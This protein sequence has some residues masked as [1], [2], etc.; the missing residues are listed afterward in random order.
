[1]GDQK[2]K[3]YNYIIIGG[4]IV[5]SGILRDLSLHDQSALLIDKK[6][7]N[8]QTSQSSSK[9][10]HGGIRYLE[11]LDFALVLEALRE[12]NHW[13]K[14]APDACYEEEFHFPI[15]KESKYPFWML[16]IGLFLYDLL[17][18]FKNTPHATITG[19]SL[20]EK[21]GFL[22]Q[23]NLKGVGVYCDAVVDDAKLGLDCIY[24]ALNNPKVDAINYKEVIEVSKTQEGYCVKVKDTLNGA[25][26]QFHCQSVLFATGP[27]TDQVMKKLNLP[28][29]PR[30]VPSKG[31]HIWLSARDLNIKKSVVLQTKDERVIFIIPQGD[32]ILVGTTENV[33]EADENYFDL[34]PSQTEI[35][36]LVE[37]I[38]EYFPGNKITESKIVASY[39]GVRPLVKKAGKN[40]S[41]LS[42]HH[43]VIQVMPNMFAIIGGKYT[44]FRVMAADIV[45]KA[46]KA[47]HTRYHSNLSLAPLKS[48]SIA[49]WLQSF[50]KEMV[51][52][53]I[54]KEKVRTFEDL[55][56]RRLSLHDLDNLPEWLTDYQERLKSRR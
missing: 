36:Y 30:I 22:K 24:D 32:Y 34:K 52:E 5:G 44:T 51:D 33:L 54:E 6:D 19:R 27:F 37:H 55:Y 3:H 56:R 20:S 18:F 47:N 29:Q 1:M 42:R 41:K 46:F 38:N 21:V 48:K 7:F 31:S 17:S 8:S 26:N 39:A 23:E 43:Q 40:S 15:Y 10:L 13:L 9:M 14:V 49:P 16:R 2:I 4:G 25:I 11:N 12:K 45:K 53:I 28:W 50:N 35:D